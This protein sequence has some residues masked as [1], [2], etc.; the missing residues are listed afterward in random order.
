MSEDNAVFDVSGGSKAQE[1]PSLLDSL[2]EELAKRIAK[3]PVS[4]TIPSRPKITMQYSVDITAADLRRWRHAARM[5]G[6]KSEDYDPLRFSAILLANKN[7]AIIMDGEAITDAN[8]DNLTAR[9]TTIQ[10]FVNA[11]DPVSTITELYG[12]D[13]HVLSVASEVIDAAGFGDE[14]ED[15]DAADPISIS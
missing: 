11:T 3:Q 9:D 15:D 7:T 5:K 14:D 2:K 8:G 4:Y 13:G 12:F 1:N 10:S 6:R